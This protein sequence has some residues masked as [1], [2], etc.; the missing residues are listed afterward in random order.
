MVID[1][2]AVDSMW[3]VVRSLPR[4]Q[5]AAIVLR[6]YEDLT[7]AE[8]AHLLSKPEGTVKSLIHRGLGRLKGEV[9]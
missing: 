6:F 3:S 5:R 2:P 1:D 4:D 9:G 7:I 8:I